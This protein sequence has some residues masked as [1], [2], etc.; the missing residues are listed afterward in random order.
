MKVVCLTR[1]VGS[2]YESSY[3]MGIKLRLFEDL[4]GEM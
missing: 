1:E 2:V 3:R 4:I